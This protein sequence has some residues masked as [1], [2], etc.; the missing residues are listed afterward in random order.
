MILMHWHSNKPNNDGADLC[1]IFLSFFRTVL[2]EPIALCMTTKG[3]HLFDK[4]V[5]Q[6]NYAWLNQQEIA[7]VIDIFKARSSLFSI[8]HIYVDGSFA[9]RRY[10]KTL[11]WPL[12]RR[13]EMLRDF[14]WMIMSRKADAPMYRYALLR[15]CQQLMYEKASVPGF[16]RNL[17]SAA[18]GCELIS[19]VLSI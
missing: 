15:V 8:N 10:H 7:L 6:V 16:I 13:C 18:Q 17:H 2:Y 19:D 11:I 3:I 5:L 12:R 4:Q 1:E 14:V 9:L